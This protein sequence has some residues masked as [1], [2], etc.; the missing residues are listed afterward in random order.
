[1]TSSMTANVR[2]A[3][4][5]MRHHEIHVACRHGS[6]L[7]LL[8]FKPTVWALSYPRNH[9]NCTNPLQEYHFPTPLRHCRKTAVILKLRNVTF[10]EFFISIAKI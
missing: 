1:M 8:P 9:T 7:L 5:Q 6:D 10:A 2:Y 3:V 4:K